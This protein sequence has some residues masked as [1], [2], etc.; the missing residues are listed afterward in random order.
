[1]RR[2]PE[3]LTHISHPASEVTFAGT[4]Q[5][6]DFTLMMPS[7]LPSDR[8][9]NESA[10]VMGQLQSLC[11]PQTLIT[12][13]PLDGDPSVICEAGQDHGILVFCDCGVASL[14]GELCH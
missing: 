5:V 13:E 9:Y 14:D 3:G 10:V 1:M 11:E 12:E 7:I 6:G 4:D 8:V 2:D